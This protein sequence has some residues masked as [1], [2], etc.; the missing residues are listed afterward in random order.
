MRHLIALGYVYAVF[1]L[2]FL[3]TKTL[4]A[5]EISFSAMESRYVAEIRPLVHRLCAD[6]HS[7]E[8]AE[9]EVDLARFQSLADVRKQP[10][11][12]QQVRA[13]LDTNQMPPPDSEQPTAEERT[14]LLA[15]VREYLTLEAS[16]RAGDPG[17]V[18]LRR[19]NNAEYTYT[20]RDLTEVESLAPAREFPAD[21]AAGEGFTNTGN[22]LVMSPALVTKYLDAAKGISEHAVLLPHGFRFSPR[23]TR[24]DWT[25]ESLTRIRD[26]YD[27]HS[28]AGGGT[29][30]NLQGIQFETNQGGRLAVDKYLAA[31]LDAREALGSGRRSLDEVAREHGLNARYLGTLWRALTDDADSESEIDAASSLLLNHL[32]QKWRA[33]EPK[34]APRLAAE[35][36]RW[37]DALWKFNSIGH[38]GR[39]LGRQD[40]P[41]AWME[42]VTPLAARQEF[43]QK[44][45]PEPGKKEITIYLAA[46]DAGDGN[47]HDYVVWENPRLVAPGRADL[48]LRDVRAVMGGLF[49]YRE[50]I[51]TTAS[52]CLA[53]AAELEANASMAAAVVATHPDEQVVDVVARRYGVDPSVLSAWL[54]YLG[55]GSGAS[56][57]EGHLTQK[58]EQSEGYDFIKGWVGADALSVLANS[59]DQHVRVPG[60]MK[61]HGVALHPSPTQR[62]LVG[63]RSPVSANLKIEGVVQHA[64]PECGNGV[65]WGLELRRGTTRQRLAAGVAHG[66]AAVK[67]GPLESVR[68]LPGD[69]I[70]MV[71]GPRDGNHSCDL[72]A[73]DLTLTSDDREWDLAREVSP[74]ILA[75]NP[76]SDIFG[77]ADVWHFYGEPDSGE[78]PSSIPAG[79]ILARWHSA[80]KQEDRQQLGDELQQMLRGDAAEIAEGSA[81]AT[82]YRHLTS[83][84]GPLLASV[85]TSLLAQ[86]QDLSTDHIVQGLAP[87][88]FGRHPSGEVIDAANLCV[89]AP[90][91]IE[92]RLPADLVDGYEFVT[93]G[94]LHR[95]T[96][97][98]GSVQLQIL[99][100]RPN[101]LE[102]SP[103]LPVIV[104]DDSP[105]RERLEYALDAMRQLFPAALCYTKIVP[106]DEVVTLTLFY[107]EDDQLRRLMLSDEE[108]CELD[109]LWDELFYI[110]QEPL[111]LAAAFEQLVEYATQ[112]SPQMVKAF[113]PM[114]GPVNDRAASFE[115]R[116][117]DTESEHL[118]ALLSFAARAYRRPLTS[119]ESEQ[120]LGLHANLRTQE[121]AHDDAFRLTLARVL[122]APAF[123]YRIEQVGPGAAQHAV[124]D[125]EL[126]GRLSYFLWSSLPDEELLQVAAGGRLHDDDV[127]LAQMR[128][129]LDSPKARRLATEFAGQWL[130]IHDFHEHDEK[131]ER[132]FPTFAA[133][134]AAMYEESLLLF[135]DLVQNDGSVL[136][137]LDADYTYLNEDLAKH[138]GIPGVSGPEW[139]RVEGVRKYSRGGILTQATTLSKQSGASRTSPILRGNWISEVVLGQRLPRPPKD[140][141]VLADAP[142]EG[143][144]ERQLIEKH[145]SDPACAKCHV[146]IDP[147]GFAL[148]H[149]DAIGRFRER[150]TA[151]L[152]IDAHT[153]LQDGTKL[154]GHDGLRDYLLT[155]R[156]DDFL[157]QF[158]RKLL[159]YALGRSVQLSDEP[160]LADIQVALE[161]RQFRVTA[162]LE[163]IVLSRQ[164]R[165]IRGRDWE[166]DE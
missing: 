64:H 108:A 34:D 66:H 135:T 126:A 88:L 161:E 106:V 10:R 16:A 68:V 145:S 89:Q 61:P 84:G 130:H 165:E 112:D 90:A 27:R 60:N 41:Q 22:A 3:S 44:L 54:E 29:A 144:T 150:D 17:R 14:R 124:T 63:W 125:Y 51:R 62:I 131:S 6:C 52:Q 111:L 40:G 75:G 32:R 136:D 45:E 4:G 102:L 43:R 91:T 154:Q 65:T 121:V 77:N 18:V 69:V 119:L 31:T 53:A 87:E 67:F 59:S 1:C 148:E 56:K 5:E 142:P 140:V 81:D 99:S 37:Q 50:L 114:H 123:L 157:R 74:N 71:I 48:A 120:L 128:R 72:T 100:F 25:E 147:F 70:A 118:S 137:L 160:L 96:G 19:L 103:A 115:Q 35:I 57:M 141:P 83:L 146:R 28:D 134:R 101:R 164:F 155:E 104:F 30:V 7:G 86:P 110:S 23:T 82:L 20:L 38:I 149:F 15:W 12:W 42:P 9:A 46:S 158:S 73:V 153:E 55:I 138:Y 2:T 105:V 139:R 113:E 79:S 163:V 76:L 11:V 24:R 93:T 13:M 21:S 36:K 152:P 47:E 143:L 117:L 109:R 85:R 78:I 58:M 132:H 107:R 8:S 26:F 127:L 95:P 162:A 156:R 151:G 97:I 122:V 49:Q 116:L 94:T 98:E 133:L 33:A 80:T 39:H 129:M 92:I 166:D 159:G